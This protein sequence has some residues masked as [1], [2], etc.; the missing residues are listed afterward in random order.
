MSREF[1]D[2]FDDWIH[3]YE[4]SVTGEDPE[5]RDV[6][7]GYDNIL[8]EVASRA[9]GTVLEF[10]TG[11]GNLTAKLVE[12]G[13]NII[14]FEPNA[15]MRDITKNRFPSVE[16]KDGDLLLFETDSVPI[17]TI[18]STYVFHHLTD[19]A[20]G[21]AL[22]KYSELLSTTGKIVF[23]DTVFE[24]EEAKRAQIAKE[25]SRG[26]HKV[27]DD[28]EREYY[29]TLPVIMGLFIGAGFEVACKQLNDYVW[30]I[31]ATKK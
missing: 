6:F 18:V 1:V 2:I 10:G 23:A 16:I 7:E 4:A 14:G 21:E 3:S 8:N 12:K 31:D 20:K 25:R 17:D 19:V 28:L 11:T 29:T 24:T 26:F 9:T 5:Y 15:A 22:K 27:A 13:H 30:L